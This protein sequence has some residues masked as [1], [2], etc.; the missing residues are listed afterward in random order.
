MYITEK[1]YS[2]VNQFLRAF[3]AQ[4]QNLNRRERALGASTAAAKQHL[5]F[6]EPGS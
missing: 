2:S 3:S 1:L 6:A 4:V 5:P